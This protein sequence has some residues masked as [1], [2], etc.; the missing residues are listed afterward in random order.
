MKVAKE[1][2][3]INKAIE[4]FEYAGYKVHMRHNHPLVGYFVD[5]NFDLFCDHQTIFAI[6]LGDD[7]SSLVEESIGIAYCSVKD[8]FNPAIGAQIAFGRAMKEFRSIHTRRYVKEI[9]S[10]YQ[11]WLNLK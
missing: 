8:Q 10:D 7:V 5:G 4:A 1:L 9:F 3:A 6:T 2:V 11:D